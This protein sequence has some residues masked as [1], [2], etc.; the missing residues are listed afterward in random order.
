[1]ERDRAAFKTLDEFAS[2]QK[3]GETFIE[4]HNATF[5]ESITDIV[6][7]VRQDPDTFVFTFID[8]TGW[9][10]FAMQRIR[11]LIRL[12]PSEVLVNFM[13]SHITRWISNEATKDQ[14][15]ETFGSDVS[16]EVHRL[17][18]DDR[19]D[20]CVALYSTA[21]G[22]AG[23]F[24]IVCPAIILK[25]T[26]QRPHFHLIYGTRS[27]RGVEVF[28]AAEKRAMEQMEKARAA[29]EEQ[30][31]RKADRKDCLRQRK[32]RNRLT[33][34]LSARGTLPTLEREYLSFS[35]LAA[36]S[37]TATRGQPL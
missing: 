1:M 34:T 19:T 21:L 14:L 4:T 22:L 16:D 8:P 18:G 10:G 3:D 13:T 27:D 6:N 17:S 36:A 24:P 7:F 28:K 30:K 15:V 2:S 5:E 32:C 11:P 35:E 9:A 33:I 12:Q 29:A 20:R 31:K 23:N 26:E 25:P 37:C